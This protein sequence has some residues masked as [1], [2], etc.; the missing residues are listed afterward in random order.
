MMTLWESD[1]LV[2]VTLTLYVPG[3]ALAV[4][5]FRLELPAPFEV[6]VIV[7]G[8]R[9]VEGPVG[10]TEAA[11]VTVPVNELRLVTVT[12]DLPED[13]WRMVNEVGLAERPKSGAGLT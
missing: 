6:R 1:P 9:L 11:M 10:E 2:A 3:A 8:L 4:V 12:V 13:P 7:E 5:T